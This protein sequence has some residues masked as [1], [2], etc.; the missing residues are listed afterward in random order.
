MLS[1]IYNIKNMKI[2][3]TNK[4]IIIDNFLNYDFYNN[5]IDEIKNTDVKNNLIFNDPY[6]NSQ[7]NWIVKEWIFCQKLNLFLSSKF[8][9]NILW[10]IIWIKIQRDSINNTIWKSNTLLI[11]DYKKWESLWWHIDKTD[12]INFIWSFVYYLN[13]LDYDYSN[14]W[15]LQLGD[16]I[17][18]KISIKK[19]IIPK[20]NRLIFLN[21]NKW[22]SFHRITQISW[23][24]PRMSIHDQIF[25]IN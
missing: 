4:Y 2:Y 5:L 11:H 14:W 23:D 9:Y 7:R 15:I 3:R 17:N 25:S 10:K 21:Y 18:N 20:W 8:F 22:K 1:N 12:N 6:S 13:N 19:N 24:I 16:I